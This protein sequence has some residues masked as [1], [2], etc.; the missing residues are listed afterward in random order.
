[1]ELLK[2]RRSSR[3]FTG[4]P[5]DKDAVCDLMKAALMS[6]SGHRINPWEFILVDDK[7]VLKALST[8][9]EHGA[10]LLEGAAMAVVVMGDTTKTD[11]W[12]EDCS[13]AT[14]IMQLAAEDLGLGSPQSRHR[15]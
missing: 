13:I 7:E 12:I 11:V 1:M 14:I 5:V 10:G 3:L 4:E 15:S 2:R 6:P 8:S 9:K